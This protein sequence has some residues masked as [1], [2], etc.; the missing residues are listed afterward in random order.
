MMGWDGRMRALA[1]V[2]LVTVLEE[3]AEVHPPLSLLSV[4]VIFP[5]HSCCVDL[6]SASC[7]CCFLDCLDLVQTAKCHTYLTVIPPLP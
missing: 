5:F 4:V 1:V 2:M 3:T 7:L 6:P